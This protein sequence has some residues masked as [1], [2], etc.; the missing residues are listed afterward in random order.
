VAGYGYHKGS[1]K[2]RTPK[3]FNA[4]LATKHTVEVN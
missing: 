1:W 2:A 4:M 3:N